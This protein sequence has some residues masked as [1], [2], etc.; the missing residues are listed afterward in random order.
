MSVSQVLLVFAGSWL[1]IVGIGW[2]VVVPALRRSPG[3]RAVDGLIWNIARLYARLWHRP[4]FSGREILPATDADHDGLVVVSNHTGAID[5]LLIQAG[6]RFLIRWMMAGDMMSPTLDWLWQDQYV[7]P[8]GRDGKDS[9]PLREA[10]RH[11]KA[12]GAVGIFPEGRITVPPRELRPFLPGVGL[13]VT[14]T[15]APVLVVWVSGTPDTNKMGE[16]LAT[17]SHARVVFVDLMEF[18]DERD[19]TVVTERLRQRIHEAS[20]WP[21]NEEI[22]PPGGEPEEGG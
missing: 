13:V 8:V 12:G 7:I 6:S 22:I 10:I 16:A 15:R 3:G 5:P 1:I 14:R 19:P 18:P 4:R 17:R 21:F 20:G 9:G 11:V 2:L